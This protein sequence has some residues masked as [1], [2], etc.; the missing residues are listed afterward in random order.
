MLWEDLDG[1]LPGASS[2][3]PSL[4]S[5]AVSPPS[6][7]GAGFLLPLTSLRCAGVSY[8]L[9]ASGAPAPYQD[10]CAPARGR[11]GRRGLHVLCHIVLGSTCCHS[12]VGRVV[13]TQPLNTRGQLPVL[14]EEQHTWRS[15]L[16][17]GSIFTRTL[18]RYLRRAAGPPYHNLRGRQQPLPDGC[19]VWATTVATSPSLL[20]V[21][22]RL[23]V[24]LR[25]YYW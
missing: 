22:P 14:E 5:A 25:R 2:L 16:V 15:Y 7:P 4:P 17:V 6:L 1:T 11:A 18:C 21:L 23:V 19:G 8:H 20:L 13:L 24:W 9:L 3:P 10:T 12:I